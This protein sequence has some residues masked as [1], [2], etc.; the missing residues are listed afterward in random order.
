[1]A[2]VTRVEGKEGV[3]WRIDYFDPKGKR[4][5]RMFKKKKDADYGD[6]KTFL[7]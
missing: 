1:M 3:S 2:K 7:D 5:R 4:I 6:H